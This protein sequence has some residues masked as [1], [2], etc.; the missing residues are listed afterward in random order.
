MNFKETK[1][2]ICL[3]DTKIGINKEDS[4]KDLEK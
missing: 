2:E 3:K 4:T 1:R